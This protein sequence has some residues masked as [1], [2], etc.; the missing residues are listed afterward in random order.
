MTNE[1][2]NE[3]HDTENF[4]GYCHSSHMTTK[5]VQS[6]LEKQSNGVPYLHTSSSQM[7]CSPHFLFCPEEY[8]FSQV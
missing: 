7:F 8:V 6:S 1:K 2:S 4:K 5:F 3:V